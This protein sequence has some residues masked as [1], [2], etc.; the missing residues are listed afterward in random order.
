MLFSLLICYNYT[1][2]IHQISI[3]T[4]K[5]ITTYTLH[6]T[7]KRIKNII[8]RLKEDEENAFKVSLPF[9]TR[10]SDLDELFKKSY[11]RLLKLRK[12]Q[13]KVEFG[14]FVYLFGEKVEVSNLKEKYLLKSTPADLEAFYHLFKKILLKHLSDEV[15]YYREVM[16]IKASYK[17]RIRKMKTRWGTNSSRTMTLTFNERIIHFHP[18]IIKSLVVHELAHHTIHGH[19]HDFYHY[20]ESIYPGYKYYDKLL[21]EHH[22]ECHF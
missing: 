6:L 16:N 22:Y 12:K 19:G 21:K 5:G 7:Y 11:V 9:G 1:M 4:S 20:L 14:E 18:K 17:I 8:F 2:K 10:L 15:N 3:P 13:N